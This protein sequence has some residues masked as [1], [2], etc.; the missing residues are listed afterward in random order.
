MQESVHATYKEGTWHIDKIS[1]WYH[2]YSD[3]AMYIRYGHGITRRE[4]LKGNDYQWT[5][6]FLFRKAIPIDVCSLKS[7]NDMP[8]NGYLEKMQN[9]Q[10]EIFPSLGTMCAGPSHIL[11]AQL[12]IMFWGSNIMVPTIRDA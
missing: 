5:T 6:L 12:K 10:C 7:K 11:S 3:Q 2:D 4:S 1:A 8:C 9:C